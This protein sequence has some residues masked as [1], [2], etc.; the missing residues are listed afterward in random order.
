MKNNT[1]IKVAKKYLNQLEEIDLDGGEYWA[2][3]KR[4]FYFEE[5]GR[6]THTAHEDTQLE[7]LKVIRSLKPC[8]CS[9][10]EELEK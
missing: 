3:S 8:N 2:Y 9:E 4:G 5:M 7:L 10:C 1:K 6:G